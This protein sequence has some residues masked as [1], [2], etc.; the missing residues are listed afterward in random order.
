[1][2][3][4]A[5]I[6]K[7]LTISEDQAQA[8]LWPR[9]ANELSHTN[10]AKDLYNDLMKLRRH[11]MDLDLHGIFISDYYRAR[12]IPR[13]FRV[14][15]APT[16]GRQNPELCKKWMNI[17][18]KSSL[19][20]MVIVGEEVGKELILIKHSIQEF[21]TTNT[22]ALQLAAATTQMLKLQDD[23]NKYKNELIWFKKQKLAKVNHDYQYHQL[24]SA[25]DAETKEDKTRTGST[26]FLEGDTFPQESPGTSRMDTRGARRMQS[27]AEGKREERNTS[28]R[29][30]PPLRKR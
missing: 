22:L 19:D 12:R 2:G 7:T 21:E 11:E 29:G 5:D 9:T 4:L 3:A 13:G 6:A 8:V 15:N 27:P 30:K 18:N 20:W 16:I 26:P 25:S 24:I 1:S 28:Y 14:R 17:A 23:I 10:T